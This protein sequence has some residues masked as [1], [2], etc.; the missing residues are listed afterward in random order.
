MRKFLIDIKEWVKYILD[1]YREAEE[2]LEG[3]IKSEK[4]GKKSIVLFEITLDILVLTLFW[5]LFHSYKLELIISLIL[6]PLFIR[7]INKFNK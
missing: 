3:V 1:E 4:D 6:L 5:F 2:E 7:T